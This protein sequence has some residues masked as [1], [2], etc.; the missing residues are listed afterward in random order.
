MPEDSLSEEKAAAGAIA[1]AV[2]P[3]PRAANDFDWLD[4]VRRYSIIGACVVAGVILLLIVLAL[5][6]LNSLNKELVGLNKA[7]ADKRGELVQTQRELEFVQENLKQSNGALRTI[8]S[9]SSRGVDVEPP[10][11]E[12]PA[13]V[14]IQIAHESQRDQARAVVRQLQAAGYVVP[15]IENVEGKARPQFISDIRYYAGSGT[16]LEDLADIKRR[17]AVLG[18]NLELK[19]LPAS[20]RVRP[21]HYEIWFGDDFSSAP[22]VKPDAPYAP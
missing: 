11:S 12:I 7:V 14:Y 8:D 22:A 3:L 20:S 21:R 17:L 2:A 1:V 9:V 18:V 6:E 5:L 4:R 16:N 15:G 13:R 19:P 10:P